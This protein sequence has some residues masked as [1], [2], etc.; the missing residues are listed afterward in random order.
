LYLRKSEGTRF[1]IW[2]GFLSA[3]G[4][5]WLIA[6]DPHEPERRVLVQVKNNMA[7]PQPSLAFAVQTQEGAPPTLTWHDPSAIAPAISWRRCSATARSPRVKFGPWHKSKSWPSEPCS[8]AK[9]DLGIEIMRVMVDG[10]QLIYWLLPGQQLP[11]SVPP[12][13]IPPSL[14]EWLAPLRAEFPPSTPLDRF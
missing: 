8:G 1:R 12:E 3:C 4:S 5:G 10:K 14:E 11:P 13:V 6:R 2:I 7:P 9:E